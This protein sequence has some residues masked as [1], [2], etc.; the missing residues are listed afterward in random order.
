MCL[1]IP[2][3]VV[4]VDRLIAHC[5]AKGVQRDVSLLML[6]DEPITPGDFVMVHLGRAIRKMTPEEARSAWEVYDLMLSEE[7][8]TDRA[9]TLVLGIGNILLGDEGAGVHAVQY[10]ERNHHRPAVRIMDGGTLGFT[11]AAAV[12]D[13][14]AL[15]VFDAAEMKA[16]PGSVR[17]FE[18]AAMDEFLGGNRKRSVH[19]VGLIDLMAIATLAGR[20]PEHRALVAIQPES[21]D[22][23]ESPTDRVARAIP[24]ACGRALELIDRWRA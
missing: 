10:F 6:D 18:G 7:A 23:S 22:W 21:M 4:A 14:E 15:I 16:Q 1:G 24:A 11:L 3:Q 8:D 5:S 19:E 13:C 17:L 20:L 9:K 2:M 12:E